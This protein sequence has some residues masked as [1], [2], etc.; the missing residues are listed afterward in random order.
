MH[1]L[2]FSTKRVG[3]VNPGAG[4]SHGVLWLLEKIQEELL[5]FFT[6]GIGFPAV[7]GAVV[8][9]IPSGEHPGL[10][11]QIPVSFH[12]S[13]GLIPFPEDFHIRRVAIDV[14][15]DKEKQIRLLI[16]NRLVNR[17]ILFPSVRVVTGAK[18]NFGH[19]VFTDNI[20]RELREKRRRNK[21]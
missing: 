9:I 17:F 5:R 7:I 21:Q 18:S 20:T 2:T 11:L 6:H 10:S 19:T 16:Q 3:G 4:P 14:V 13:E 12:F 15:T 8:M 1:D